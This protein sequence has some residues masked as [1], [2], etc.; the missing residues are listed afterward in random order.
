MLL[1]VHCIAD[2]DHKACS[3]VAGGLRLSTH[4]TYSSAQLQFL[5]FCSTY[6]LVPI[7]ASEQLLL[8]FIAYSRTP[9]RALKAESLKVYLSAINSLHTLMGL[10]PAPTSAP[11]VRLALKCISESGPGPSQCSPITFLMLSHIFASLPQ[12]LDHLAWKAILALGFFAGLRGAEYSLVPQTEGGSGSGPRI[13]DAHFA[14]APSGPF[15]LFTVVRSKT[16]PHGFTVP[17]GCSSSPVCAVCCLWSYL[18]ARQA[19]SPFTQGDPL[20]LF[21]SGSQLSKLALNKFIKQAVSSL[22]LDPRRFSSHSLRAGVATTAAALSFQDHE[23]RLLGG[24]AS[25]AYHSY[26]RQSQS[27]QIGFARRLAAGSPVPGASPK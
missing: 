4:K 23:V 26:I 16:R 13:A 11:R 14:S 10:P 25:D 18:S 24:W 12:S 5:R 3:L 15:L 1:I 20:F 6:S 9:P 27:A 22:G 21:L 2:L 19:S 8:W 17:V 7:P